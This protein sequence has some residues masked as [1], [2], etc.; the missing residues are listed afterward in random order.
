M[1]LLQGGIRFYLLNKDPLKIFSRTVQREA[2]DIPKRTQHYLGPSGSC[3]LRQWQ[4][5]ESPAR[6]WHCGALGITP[7]LHNAQHSSELVPSVFV[8]GC[9]RRLTLVLVS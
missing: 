1:E 9:K 8:E 7:L 6:G 5:F 2:Q 3:Q 4:E